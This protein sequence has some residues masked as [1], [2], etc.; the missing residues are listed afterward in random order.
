LVFN[1][2]LGPAGGKNKD[3]ARRREAPIAA[4]GAAQVLANAGRSWPLAGN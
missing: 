3:F 4:F 1:Q 2:N